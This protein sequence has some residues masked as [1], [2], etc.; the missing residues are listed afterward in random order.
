ML[1]YLYELLKWERKR[2]RD[3]HGKRKKNNFSR[4]EK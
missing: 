3:G 4:V 1:I 2:E